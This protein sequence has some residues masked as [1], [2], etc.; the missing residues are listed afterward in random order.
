MFIFDLNKIFQIYFWDNKNVEFLIKIE[1]YTWNWE[2]IIDLINKKIDSSNITK[3]KI[4]VLI[5]SFAGF[6]KIREIFI[7]L[8]T[9]KMF[10]LKVEYGF[11]DYLDLN[12][13]NI[14]LKNNL[15]LKQIKD[16]NKNDIFKLSSLELPYP[17]RYLNNL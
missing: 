4:I 13:P 7:W 16:L 9:W 3:I 14:D 8:S 11:L 2:E 10:E 17:K 1:E 15:T 6:S 12:I 5:G